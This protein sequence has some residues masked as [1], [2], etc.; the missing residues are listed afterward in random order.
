VRWRAAKR[1]EGPRPDWEPIF[2]VCLLGDA[3]CGKSELLAPHVYHMFDQKYIN[4]IG[5]KVTKKTIRYERP[6]PGGSAHIRATFLIWD[7]L[8]QK[9]YS[10]LHPVYYQGAQAAVI[11]SRATA[12]NTFDSFR[13]WARSFIEVVGPVPIIFLL[14]SGSEASAAAPPE[15]SS[16]REEFP[17]S[18]VMMVSTADILSMGKALNEIGAIV[19]DD[20]LA[21]RP[22]FTDADHPEEKVSRRALRRR[23]SKAK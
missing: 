2:K 6:R 10:K 17:R 16:L 18:S 7:I 5:T 22:R 21:A 3:A 19:I 4:T 11:V 14:N 9:Q 12:E 8:G 13:L 23:K 1:E 20:S 15:A